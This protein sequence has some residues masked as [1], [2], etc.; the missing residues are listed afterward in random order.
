MTTDTLTTEEKR[1]LRVTMV[2]YFIRDETQ[3]PTFS[4]D[5]AARLLFL[6]WRLIQRGQTHEVLRQRANTLCLEGIAS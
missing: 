6:R 3:A 4:R 2:W 5:E 1:A